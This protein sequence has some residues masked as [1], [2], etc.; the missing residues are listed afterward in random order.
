MSSAPLLY[1]FICLLVCLFV[2]LFLGLHPQHME[3]PRLGVKLELQVLVYTT[4]TAVPD[5]SCVCDIQH[6][7]QICQIINP[8]SKARY[9]THVLMDSSQYHHQC[10]KTGFLFFLLYSSYSRLLWLFWAHMNFKIRFSVSLKKQAEI[11]IG[12]TLEFL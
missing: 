1:L 8:L 7:S 11:L 10:A 12:I 6:S 2:C 5:P 3:V 9:Q 4:A